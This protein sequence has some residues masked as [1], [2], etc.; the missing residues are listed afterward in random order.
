MLLQHPMS[1]VNTHERRG[2]P[3][4]EYT[5]RRRRLLKSLNG[6]AAVVFAGEGSA[7][8]LGKWQPDFHFVYLTGISNEPGAAVLFHPSADDPKRRV[9]L[10]LRP[11]DPDHDPW[12]GYRDAIGRLLRQATRFAT[13]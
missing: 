8:L 5:Q 9:T 1:T 13:V 12:D 4:A 6:A 3:L 10:F 2:I 7:P 11:I